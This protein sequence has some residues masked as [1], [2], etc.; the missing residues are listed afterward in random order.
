VAWRGITIYGENMARLDSGS[1]R[2]SAC[3]ACTAD[4]I[5]VR[6]RIHRAVVRAGLCREPYVLNLCEP[7][8]ARLQG[9]LPKGGVWVVRQ[10]QPDGSEAE[11]PVRQHD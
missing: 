8:L 10:Y 2:R 1:D 3:S 4:Q 9:A 7:H 5:Y 11:S 6:G